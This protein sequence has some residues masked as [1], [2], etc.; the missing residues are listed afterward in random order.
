MKFYKIKM[1]DLCQPP[2]DEKWNIIPNKC[3]DGI[4]KGLISLSVKFR[5]RIID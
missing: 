4:N 3:E 1:G 2:T 5:I